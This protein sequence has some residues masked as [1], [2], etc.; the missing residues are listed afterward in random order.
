[1][2]AHRLALALHKSVAE[3]LQLSAREVRDWQLFNQRHP[4]P[5]DLLDAH[6]AVQ[7][8]IIAN[9]NRDPKRNPLPYEVADFLL[10]NR[11][12]KPEP[13]YEDEADRIAKAFGGS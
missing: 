7:S 6:L 4:F 10:V 13:E 11:V 2:F 3:I 12:P 8:C 9:G 5:V 1:V